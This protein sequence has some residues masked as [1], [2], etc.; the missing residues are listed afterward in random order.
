MSEV[1]SSR[2]DEKT[3]RRMEELRHINWSEVM[4]KAILKKIE[5]ESRREVDPVLIQEAIRIMDEVR[6]PVEGYDG[7]MEIRRWREERR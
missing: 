5:E 7:T 6:R 3:K 2:V 4:R 1:V